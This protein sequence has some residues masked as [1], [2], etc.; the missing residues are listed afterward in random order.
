MQINELVKEVHQNAIN[1]GWWSEERSFGELIALC[2]SELSEALEEYRNG[3]PL[4]KGE[5]PILYYSGGGYRATAPTKCSTKPEGIAPE[6]ADTVI[7]IMD[8]CGKY[9]IDLEAAILEKHEYNKT[10]PYKHGGKVI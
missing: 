2:H 9:G 7:R 6:L 10:R 5:L 4:I 8:I 3:H 1:H